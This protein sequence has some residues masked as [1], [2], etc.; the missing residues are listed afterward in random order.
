MAQITFDANQTIA[1]DQKND[2]DPSQ[3]IDPSKQALVTIDSGAP[4]SSVAA[5]PAN[6]PSQ[7]PSSWSGHD[8]TGGS[9][10]A[11]YSVFYTDNGGPIQTF[12][13]DTTQRSAV[14]TGQ[15]GHTYAFYSLATDNVGNVQPTPTTA[16]ATTTVSSRPRRS[17][18]SSAPRRRPLPRRHAPS[19]SRSRPKTPTAL[20]NLSTTAPFS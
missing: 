16:Q 12:E 6:S 20:W 8:D 4:T 2:E 9:G 7:F 3:G 13:Q 15:L 18:S 11:T 1:T 19:A 10:L 17:T 14:F 5:L